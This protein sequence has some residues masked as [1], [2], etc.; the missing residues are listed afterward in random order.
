[1]KLI[2]D[3]KRNIFYRLVKWFTTPTVMV[4]LSG[5]MSCIQ[6][7]NYLSSLNY[8]GIVTR[9]DENERNRAQ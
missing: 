8:K 2:D 3:K 5:F 1:M 4:I 7:V 9:R 6:P